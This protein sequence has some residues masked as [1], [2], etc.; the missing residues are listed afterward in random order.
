MNA[1]RGILQEHGALA[2]DAYLAW[3]QLAGVD[4][5]VTEAP[6]H[7]LRPASTPVSAASTPH[8]A[9]SVTE[10]KPQD[11]ES[12]HHWLQRESGHPEQRWPG[13][14]IP[15]A[16]ATDAAL[17]IVTDMPDPADLDAGAL[18][19]DRAGMLCDAMLR[20]I[21][22]DRTQTYIASLFFR[23]P[24]G[25]MVEAADLAAAADRMRTHV[26]LA[27]PRRLLLLGDRTL[28]ALMPANGD[29]PTHSLR[30]F[31]HDSGIVPAIATFHPRLLL[32][33]PAAKAECWRALQSLIEENRP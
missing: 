24:P 16:G 25:G 7:W 19:A 12:F 5:A 1:M 30:D 22:L 21:R 17:M 15:A 23:R 3:W 10:P 20:A 28:R 13:R 29:I 33:Q 14:A 8:P 27:R 6:V 11:L 18:L 26:H 4:C 31:N 2:T 9:T 32:G